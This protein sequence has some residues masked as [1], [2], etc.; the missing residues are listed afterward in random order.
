MKPI[1][2]KKGKKVKNNINYIYLNML[3]VNMRLN[4]IKVNIINMELLMGFIR[5]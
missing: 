4:T 3:R 2:K 1:S 5:I